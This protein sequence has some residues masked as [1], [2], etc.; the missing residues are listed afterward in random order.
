MKRKVGIQFTVLV[1]CVSLLLAACSKGGRAGGNNLTGE[2]RDIKAGQSP[3]WI[4]VPEVITVEDEHADYGRMQ[5]V[6]NTFCYVQQEGETEDGVKN[7][8]RYSLTS[9][10]LTSVPIDWPEGGEN[11]DAGAWYFDRDYNVYLT[12]NVYPADYSSMTRFLCKFDQEGNCLFAKDITE[13][14]GR[15]ALLSGMTVDSQGRLF[16]FA[17]GGE[18]L[19]YT[20]DGAYHGSVS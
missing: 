1:I 12:A 4:Y 20:G 14:L 2:N 11:W 6:N 9:H 15:G 3:E 8:C 10:K 5:L 7:I 19:L 17:N 18:I 16:I 13:Q